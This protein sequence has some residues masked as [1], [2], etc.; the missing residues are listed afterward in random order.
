[1]F[2]LGHI[3]IDH[4]PVLLAPLED[5]TDPPFRHLCKQQGADIMYTEFI[6]SDGLI[7]D[8][9]K[10]T[11]KLDFEES[12]RPIGIQIF[13]NNIDSMRKAAEYAASVNPDI[14]DI[15]FGCAVKK[16]ASKGAGSGAMNDIPK[17]VKTT[18]AVVNSTSIPVTVKTR[19]G[20]DD[21]NKNI[22]EI[23]ERLQD[24]GIQAITIHGRTRT[25]KYSQPADWSLIAEVK[26]NQR[27][28]IPVIGNGDIFN[29][30]MA[31]EK[32]QQ[33]GVDAI[34]IGRAV[35]GYPWIFREIH[36]FLNTCELLPP[37]GIR[38]RTKTIMDHIMRSVAWK[39]EKGTLLEMRRF[40]AGYFKGTPGFKPFKQKLQTLD[41]ID[42]VI[43]MLKEIETVYSDTSG[44]N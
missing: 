4:Y 21:K 3:H 35:L 38:E 7:R 42:E 8:A 43:V 29:A 17:M 2:K 16:V 6:S 25:M 20:Y 41:S 40:Y 9:Q 12:E 10:S 19:L 30:A 18:E 26:K 31:R 5:I 1:M 13:G 33:S 14:I 39:G 11:R 22:V 34:M 15:N 36:H 28:K 37:P 23:A 27:M 24:V 32:Q 44:L